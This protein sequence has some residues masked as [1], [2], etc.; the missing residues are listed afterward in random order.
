MRVLMFLRTASLASSSNWYRCSPTCKW[1]YFLPSSSM[2]T[3]L[4]TSPCP[5]RGNMVSLTSSSRPANEDP[6]GAGA[7]SSLTFISPKIVPGD[8]GREE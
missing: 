7:V 8:C 3:R 1:W 2:L 5:S 4:G 6:E